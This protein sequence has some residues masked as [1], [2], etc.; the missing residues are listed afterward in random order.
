MMKQPPQRIP[1]T[2]FPN[3]FVSHVGFPDDELICLSWMMSILHCFLSALSSNDFVHILEHSCFHPN[4]EN[5]LR[6]LSSEYRKFA[7]LLANIALALCNKETTQTDFEIDLGNLV[8]LVK[9]YD[10]IAKQ[11][12]SGFID[13]VEFSDDG[14]YIAIAP[15]SQVVREW[16]RFIAFFQ[17]GMIS[18][19]IK[20][21]FFGNH[22]I[23]L[24]C[25]NCL[26]A[27]PP[28]DDVQEYRSRASRSEK[29]LL[30]LNNPKDIFKSLAMKVETMTLGIK[31]TV[32]IKKNISEILHDA[33]L[34]CTTELECPGA[35]CGNWY[36]GQRLRFLQAPTSIVVDSLSFKDRDCS[37]DKRC[38]GDIQKES[39]P[40]DRHYELADVDH[41]INL[42]IKVSFDY[43]SILDDSNKNEFGGT[44]YC[45]YYVNFLVYTLGEAA[46][47]FESYKRDTICAIR[48]ANLNHNMS[49]TSVTDNWK[50]IH[51][52]KITSGLHNIPMDY[53]LSL[54]SFQCCKDS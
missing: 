16:E 21:Q 45:T 1:L 23:E 22:I 6:H 34:G 18:Q 43:I 53:Q 48:E 19:S 13:T 37:F 36:V 32:G 20:A 5:H 40:V 29:A 46:A 25:P 42:F 3:H 39:F 41:D 49:A 35:H 14:S 33:F 31:S 7:T 15:N 47:G 30:M 4:S 10:P 8:N 38:F 54:I 27:L 24:T 12:R 11:S 44:A 50:V 26:S 51:N 28:S 9:T 52:N 17:D 2:H